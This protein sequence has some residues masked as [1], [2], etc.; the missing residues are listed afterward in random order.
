[1]NV[2][3]IVC[4]MVKKSHTL[5]YTT[6]Y[7]GEVELQF[8]FVSDKEKTVFEN[9]H[10]GVWIMKD[11][12]TVDSITLPE[13]GVHIDMADREPIGFFRTKL[14][15]NT[16]YKLLCWTENAGKTFSTENFIEIGLPRKPHASWIWNGTTYVAPIP[17]PGDVDYKWDEASKTWIIK[18]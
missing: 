9:I 3:K 2:L 5:E 17:V 11:S 4:D 12:T 10:F 6:V 14:D 15:P 18:S 8:C 13:T 1:M 16:N 7:P